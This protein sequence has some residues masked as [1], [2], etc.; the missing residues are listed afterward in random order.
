MTLSNVILFNTS[1]M[2]GRTF[3]CGRNSHISLYAK[4]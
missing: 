2:I 1:C 4:V 3:E